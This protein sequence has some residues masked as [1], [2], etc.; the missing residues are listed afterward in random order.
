MQWTKLIRSGAITAIACSALSLALN[1]APVAASTTTQDPWGPGYNLL[2]NPGHEHPGTYFGGRGEINVTW[3]WVPFWEESP[4]GYDPRDQH[5]R[6]P[7]FR[8]VFSSIYPDRVH[9]GG[10][11]DRWFN[12]YA[13]NHAAGIM[14]V[15]KNVPVGKP[16]RFTSWVQLWSSNETSEPA[17]STD[18]GNLK[19]R[20]CIQ[21][22]GGPRNMV[23]D[24]LKCS[25]WA[26][27]Y[28][29][30]AQISVDATPTNSTVLVLLQSNADIPVQHN[31][32]Y[33]DDS[34]FEVLNADGNGICKGAGFI[35]SAIDGN[36][37]AIAATVGVPAS[38]GSA[39][40]VANSFLGL[41]IRQTPEIVD[42]NIIG[43]AK[44]GDSLAVPGITSDN[45]WYQI[46]YNGKVAYVY[47]ALTL[48]NAAAKAA[49]TVK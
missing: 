22:D 26:Q 35:P 11:S 19:I 18:D 28:D 1:A 48:P 13:L 46:T 44:E 43:F 9:S 49:P 27:P 37:A 25:A 41:N 24:A 47:A 15:V 7:E 29:V 39:K 31:D 23:S 21:V 4:A 40:T 30:W 42:G 8:P 45:T 5:Y 14:Q 2:S 34:C 36:P 33:A 10:G 17:K 38:D 12:F 16:M 6:T 32:I 3:N 20:A